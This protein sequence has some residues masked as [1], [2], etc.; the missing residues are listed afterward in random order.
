MNVIGP[1]MSW[2][3]GEG[4]DERPWTKLNP[5][6]PEIGF[7]VQAKLNG[8]E[9]PVKIISTNYTSSNT[10]LWTVDVELY[11]YNKLIIPGN[12]SRGVTSCVL[13]PP[14]KFPDNCDATVKRANHVLNVPLS[15]IAP[16][17][18]VVWCPRDLC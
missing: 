8:A 10:S 16:K 13:S 4:A 12:Y 15:S 17:R 5:M 7:R 18:G 6:Q 3:F 11:T 2:K 9:I 14:Y 1:Q